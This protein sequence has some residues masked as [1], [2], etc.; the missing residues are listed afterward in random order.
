MEKV[1]YPKV[2]GKYQ[3]Y[4]GGLYE[5]ITMATHSETGEPLVI[6]KSLLFGSVYAR[7]LNIWFDVIDGQYSSEPLY[8]FT[9]I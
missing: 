5:V 4:K 7:P 3:H 2:G 8:R 1:K 6:Y 9:E